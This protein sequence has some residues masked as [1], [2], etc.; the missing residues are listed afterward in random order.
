M[1]KRQLEKEIMTSGI[2]FS[3]S[4]SK[5]LAELADMCVQDVQQSF[6]DPNSL[7][8]LFFEQQ[9]KFILSGKNGMR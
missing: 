9:R 5:E 3:D 4:Q 1:Q 2:T 6:P 7:Q 8:R